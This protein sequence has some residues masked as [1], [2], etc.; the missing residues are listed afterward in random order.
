MSGNLNAVAK[1]ELAWGADMPGWVRLL[2]EAIDRANQRE[3]GQRLERSNAYVSR[4]LNRNYAG[5]Y[6]EAETLVRAAYG[7]EEVGCPVWGGELIPLSSC[8]RHR[9]K[10]KPTSEFDL[11]FRRYCPGCR[12]NT[13]TPGTLEEDA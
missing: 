12:N 8:V 5:S 2:A 6:E 9:R 13:D 7:A 11:K 10:A 3:V 1:A 4:V